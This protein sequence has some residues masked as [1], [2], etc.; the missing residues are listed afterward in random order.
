MRMQLRLLLAQVLVVA[1]IVV[2]YFY[3]GI[4]HSF[5]W[6]FW[7][8]DNVLHLLGGIWAAFVTVWVFGEFGFQRSFTV[9]VMGALVVGVSWEIIEY[10]W[11]FPQS[12]FVPY[13]I[14]VAKDILVDLVGGAVAYYAA[15]IFSL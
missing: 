13:E 8:W 11:D 4:E 9:F 5:L 12:W 7:W 10:V 14:D 3:L 1:A 2:A 6:K 15:R